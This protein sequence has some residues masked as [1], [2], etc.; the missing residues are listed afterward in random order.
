[1]ANT[2]YNVS[3]G[4]ENAE[5]KTHW[6]NCGILI[7]KEDG[8][9]SMKLNCLPVGECTGWFGIFLKDDVKT[10]STKPSTPVDDFEL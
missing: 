3:Y 8:K 7:V 1:M 4:S 10:A 9:M 2:I 6:L 5:G